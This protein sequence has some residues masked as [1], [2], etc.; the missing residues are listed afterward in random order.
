MGQSALVAGFALTA[1]VLGWPIGATLAAKNVARFGLRP[2]LLFGAALL[3]AGAVAFVALGPGSTPAIAGLGSVVM[4]L[5]M[6]FLSTAAIL[7]VQGCVGWAERGVATASNIFS[8]NLGSALG[9]AVLGSVFNLG[10]ARPGTTAV[11]P[12]QI[13]RTARPHRRRH[14]R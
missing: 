5:G 7:I 11:D 14:D 1:M 9:A 4:G 3:P 12:D 13:R 10:L 8:R 2:T 6:G